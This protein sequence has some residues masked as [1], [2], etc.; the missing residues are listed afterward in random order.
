M[1]RDEPKYVPVRIVARRFNVSP[2]VVHRWIKSGRLPA[3]HVGRIYRILQK[4]LDAFAMAYRQQ[5]EQQQRRH[6]PPRRR[7]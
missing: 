5:I 4:D 2:D 7:L 1:T 3:L 6:I